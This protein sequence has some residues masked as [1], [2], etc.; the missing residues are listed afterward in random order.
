[1]LSSTRTVTFLGLL[2]Q[3]TGL[4]RTILIANALGVSLDF[5]SYNL[6]LIAPTFFGTVLS[7]WLQVGFTGRYAGLVA[8]GENHLAGSYLT[9]MI[10]VVIGL[11]SGI[12]LIFSIFP[13]QIMTL[14]LPSSETEM[15]NLAALALGLSGWILALNMTSDFLGLVLNCHGRFF[16][17]AF[18]PALNAA[19]SVVALWLWPKINLNALVWTLLLGGLAQLVYIALMVGRLKLRYFFGGKQAA[20]EVT[21][22]VLLAIPILP[23]V[24]LANSAASLVQLRA[25]E[26]GEG[27]VSMFGYATRLHSALSQVLV[28]GLG[29]VLLPHFAALWARGDKLG[30]VLVLRRLVRV[31]VLV[32]AVLAAGVWSMG[33]E[34]VEFLFGRGAFGRQ[35]AVDVAHIWFTLSLALFPFALGTFVAKLFQAMRHATAILASGVISFAVVVATTQI[36]LAEGR[37]DYVAGAMVT[38]TSVVMIFWLCWFER[39]FTAR[40]LL[41]DLIKAV[42]LTLPVVFLMLLIDGFIVNCLLSL[43]VFVSLCVRGT[44]FLAVGAT[45]VY[46]F[47]LYRWFF[48]GNLSEPN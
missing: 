16:A 23:A 39:H 5:D 32:T 1:M 3:V 15:V 45:V 19:L 7:S 28:M 17:A 25:A 33:G 10:I 40:P 9:R 29:T 44:A 35:Q 36:G 47:G 6:A 27:A 12:S 48:S 4:V 18:A 2:V 11:S 38:S 43:P 22:T 24:M 37:I 14:L 34:A 8:N 21:R 26:L 30:I 31:G 41:S 46:F 42:V 13:Q 20:S